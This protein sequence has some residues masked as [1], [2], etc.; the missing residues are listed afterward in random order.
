M[1]NKID[2]FIILLLKCS[3]KEEQ[4]NTDVPCLV[5]VYMAISY[6]EWKGLLKK[7]S[8]INLVLYINMTFHILKYSCMLQNTFILYAMVPTEIMFVY[9]W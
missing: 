8:V 7:I 1:L 9:Q 2:N 5:L 6:T 3:L 4:R